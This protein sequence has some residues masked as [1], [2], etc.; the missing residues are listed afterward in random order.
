[1]QADT[2]VEKAM[3]LWRISVEEV[4]MF[5]GIG[6]MMTSVPPLCPTED[7]G[8]RHLLYFASED[9]GTAH[10]NDDESYEKAGKSSLSSV[11]RICLSF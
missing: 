11:S 2:K 5:R 1:M 3:F 7:V 10:R 6:L 8:E 4:S 9:E